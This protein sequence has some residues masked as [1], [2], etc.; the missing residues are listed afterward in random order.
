M[1]LNTSE[2]TR[3]KHELGFNMLLVGAEPYVT[4]TRYFEQVAVPNLIAGVDTTSSTSVSAV[5]SPT[6]VTL[7]LASGTGILA[8]DTVVVDVDSA[9]E[10]VTVQAIV[11]NS[12]TV[13]LSKAH[14]GTYPVEV[15]GGVSLVRNYLAKLRR[16]SNRIDLFGARAGIKSLDKEDLVFF[17]AAH[18][19][20][21]FRTLRDMQ[22]HFRAELCRMFF[23]TG[24]IQQFLGQG[25]GGRVANY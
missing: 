12:L 5:T 21:G 24:S 19:H 22:T 14:S 20:S 11:G 2:I 23:G 13:I 6:A 8:F 9:Q 1:T 17:G 15:E 4:V 7:T 18:E 3:V 16:I 10:T 25:G